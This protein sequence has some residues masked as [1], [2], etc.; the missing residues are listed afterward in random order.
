M[1][2]IFRIAFLAWGATETVTKLLVIFSWPKVAAVTSVINKITWWLYHYV[3]F[4]QEIS[5]FSRKYSPSL[6]TI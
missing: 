4:T 1:S 6:L 5:G 2:T 3:A